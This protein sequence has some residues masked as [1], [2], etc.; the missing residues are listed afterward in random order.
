M[1]EIMAHEISR[2]YDVR[3]LDPYLSESDEIA[4]LSNMDTAQALEEILSDGR[5]G[6]AMRTEMVVVSPDTPLTRLA[7][8]MALRK[9]HF[10]IVA[11]AGLPVG[12]LSSM[13]ILQVLG[14]F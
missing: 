4:P 5:V 2:I 14:R 11:R 13:D 9:T 12:I 3:G 7:R 6:R 10:A 8:A 1:T